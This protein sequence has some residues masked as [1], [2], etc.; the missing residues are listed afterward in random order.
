MKKQDYLF[1]CKIG[2][3]GRISGG[4]WLYKN[5]VPNPLPEGENVFKEFP[6]C[7][8]GGEDYVWDGQTLTYAPLPELEKEEDDAA[9]Q[10]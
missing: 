2:P 7:R 8:N 3:D 5:V 1:K 10:D 6:E 4:V 9:D